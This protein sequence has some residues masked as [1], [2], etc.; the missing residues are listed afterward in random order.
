MQFKPGSFV[1]EEAFGVSTEAVAISLREMV[2][3]HDAPER[4]DLTGVETASE[5]SASFRMDIGQ[6]DYI[7]EVTVRRIKYTDGA[8]AALQ[9]GDRI[10]G[11]GVRYIVMEVLSEGGVW[12]RR[13]DGKAFIHVEGR[14]EFIRNHNREALLAVDASQPLPKNWR[15]M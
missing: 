6:P 3:F 9:V 13:F 1:Q 11:F 10:E 2:E 12:V 7:F 8:Q 5:D 4:T 15:R 14:E